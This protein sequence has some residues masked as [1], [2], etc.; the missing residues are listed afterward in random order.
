MSNPKI[1]TQL[2]QVAFE[3]LFK[4]HFAQLCNFAS[5]YVSDMDAAR[6]I[7]QNVFILLWKNRE[8]INTDQNVRSYLFTSVKNRCL[9]YIRDQ[10]KYRSRVLDVDIQD[11][12]ISFEEIELATDD[13]EIKIQKSL[14]ALPEKCRQVFIMSRFEEK[15]YQEIAAALD[16]SIKTVEAHMSRALRSLREDLKDH[17]YVLL[18][19]FFY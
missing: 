11:I 4:S 19:L 15:K 3:A 6:D 5:G 13:L 17:L 8:Q 12:D 10:K 14:D 9:N 18:L 1:P 2:D 16:I 7:C